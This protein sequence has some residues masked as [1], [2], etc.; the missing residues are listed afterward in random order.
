MKS[1]YKYILPILSKCIHN[2]SLEAKMQLR[3]NLIY[4]IP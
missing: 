4:R 3:E 2:L 1:N